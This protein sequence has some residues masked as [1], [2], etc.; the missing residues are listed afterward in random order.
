MIPI[1]DIE[2]PRLTTLHW[3]DDRRTADE[4]V[5]DFMQAPRR[6]AAALQAA[7]EQLDEPKQA[8][9]FTRLRELAPDPE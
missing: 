9:F 7:R 2:D 4:V 1:T 3:T 6:L 8:A 5:Q